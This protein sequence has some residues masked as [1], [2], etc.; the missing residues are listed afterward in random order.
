MKNL[1]KNVVM[2]LFITVF[3]TSCD[4]NSTHDKNRN[5]NTTK[6]TEEIVNSYEEI[7]DGALIW[8]AALDLYNNEDYSGALKKIN[9]YLEVENCDKEKGNALKAEIYFRTGNY[10]ESV[11]SYTE[12]IKYNSSEAKYYLMRGNCYQNLDKLTLACKDWDRAVNLGLE[13]AMKNIN[14]FCK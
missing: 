7:D 11:T 10:Q 4:M 12:A 2:I 14:N 1:V 5:S 3:I 9:R 13:G 8:N 6:S